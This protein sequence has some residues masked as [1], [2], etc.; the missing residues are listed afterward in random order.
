METRNDEVMGV[1]LTED[2]KEKQAAH[3][4]VTPELM[5]DLLGKEKA[6]IYDFGRKY[7]NLKYYD[8]EQTKEIQESLSKE[9]LEK[10]PLMGL[11]MGVFKSNQNEYIS[12]YDVGD[13]RVKST[14][15][16]KEGLTETVQDLIRGNRDIKN[17]NSTIDN[18]KVHFKW[19]EQFSQENLTFKGKESLEFVNKLIEADNIY[20]KERENNKFQDTM[21][22]YMP[23]YKTRL[24]VEYSGIKYD[25]E[26]MDLG[27]GVYRDLNS[28]IQEREQSFKGISDEIEKLRSVTSNKIVDDFKNNY[29][30]LFQE[31]KE[32]TPQKQEFK[33]SG[34]AFKEVEKVLSE[35]EKEMK[36]V[37]VNS[38]KKNKEMDND[39]ER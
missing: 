25:I 5:K 3:I 7:M 9:E 23:Y 35:K 24:A 31:M 13:I 34:E 28:F 29:N 26:R 20:S 37:K 11:D 14:E 1:V 33:T 32:Y 17:S 12:V 6:D 15:I 4:G 27:D 38:W 10:F 16:A 22:G 30:K 36:E 18:L 21:E 8:Y 2:E 19:S 39:K